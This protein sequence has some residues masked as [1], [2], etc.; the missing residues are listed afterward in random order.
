[1]GPTFSCEERTWMTEEQ[2]ETFDEWV[3]FLAILKF[4]GY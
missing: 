4:P 3:T 1:M 2:S